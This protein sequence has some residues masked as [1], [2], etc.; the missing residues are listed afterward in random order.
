MG[1][2]PSVSIQSD[3]STEHKV[4]HVQ[5]FPLNAV[6]S[7]QYDS[8]DP[9]PQCQMCSEKDKLMAR[10]RSKDIFTM[11]VEQDVFQDYTPS[12]YY[13]CHQ[14]KPTFMDIFKTATPTHLHQ[15]RLAWHAR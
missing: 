12:V 8:F 11:E 4:Y 14:C 15:V 1:S 3:V 5:S 6:S 13:V 10:Y 2:K 9:V 7:Q